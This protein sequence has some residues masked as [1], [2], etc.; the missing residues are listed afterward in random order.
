MDVSELRSAFTFASSAVERIREF[1]EQRIAKILKGET[2]VPL[3][4]VKSKTVLHSIPLESFAGSLKYDVLKYSSQSVRVP[5]MVIGGSWSPRINLDGLVIHSGYQ[6]RS[7]SYTQLFRNGS[8][9]AVEASWLDTEHEGKR[10]IPYA[11]VEGD[12][13][14]YLGTIFEIQKELGVRP[15][16]VIALTMTGTNGLEMAS[17][18]LARFFATAHGHTIAEPHLILPESVVEDFSEPPGKILKP[19]FDLI[20]NA[21]GYAQTKTLDDQGNWILQR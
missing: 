10:M 5:P 3:V 4:A 17:E 12:L 13:L 18:R 15:P 21:C 1:R 7:I 14:K 2:P 20:W 9:E 19:L 11:L 16:I 6:D 8:V